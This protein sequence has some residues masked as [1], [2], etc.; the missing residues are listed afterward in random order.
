[1]K[2]LTTKKRRIVY[3]IILLVL[4]LTAIIS[5]T[6]FAYHRQ[7]N[8]TK[9][10]SKTKA[11]DQ[12]KA[13]VNLQEQQTDTSGSDTESE[14][15]PTTSEAPTVSTPNPQTL[16]ISDMGIQVTLPDALSR[17]DVTYYT[18]MTPV[19]LNDSNGVAYHLL[20]SVALSTSSLTSV[21]PYC[22][23]SATSYNA[24]QGLQGAFIISKTQENNISGYSNFI[25]IGDSY[26]SIADK[27]LCSRGDTSLE[28]KQ[29]Q[30][31]TEAFKTIASS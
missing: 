12:T 15:S 26:Y 7:Q 18:N 21:E 20:G 1:M 25:K 3:L 9:S 5:V 22:V 19:T 23:A 30:L 14:S 8:T 2:K 29:I 6:A 13:V 16:Y 4:V 27:Q 10:T 11:A 24:P 31:F 28:N 17:S